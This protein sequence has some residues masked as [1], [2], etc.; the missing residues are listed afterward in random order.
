MAVTLTICLKPWL[1]NLANISLPPNPCDVSVGPTGCLAFEVQLT[2]NLP[3]SCPTL[4]PEPFL[5][6][7]INRY[8]LLCRRRGG[9]QL[10]DGLGHAA[11]LYPRRLQPRA[12]PAASS[13][14]YVAR[15]LRPRPRLAQV[16]RALLRRV[17]QC[18]VLASQGSAA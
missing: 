3:G 17:R 7:L 13:H 11:G 12:L 5:Q 15:P 6:N 9:D 4:C 10:G 14:R 16:T 18:R 2:T 8:D 1:Y